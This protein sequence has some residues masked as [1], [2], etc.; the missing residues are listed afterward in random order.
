MAKSPLKPLVVCRNRQATF[1]FEL[2]DRIE[3]G[4]VLQGTE[5]KSLRDNGANLEH[6]Y[7]RLDGGELWLIDG[8]IGPYRY[9]HSANHDSTRKR[10]LLLHSRELKKIGPKLK[11]KGL[12]LVPIEI[13]FNERG[14]AKVV[15]ALA[16]GKTLSD[17]RQDL[18]TREHRRDIEQATKSH[19]K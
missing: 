9:G 10:K 7:A 5:V 15:I 13:R 16:R 6:A 11:T 4:L 1:K 19:R 18:T 8:H 14:I 3:C 12:T 17:K 2:L